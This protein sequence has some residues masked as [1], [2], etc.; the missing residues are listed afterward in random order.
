MTP[1]LT[2][3]K[4]PSTW[5]ENGDLKGFRW[6]RGGGANNIAALMLYAAMLHRIDAETGLSKGTYNQ[7][8]DVL[9]ISREKVSRGIDVLLAHKL[10][11]SDNCAQSEYRISNYDP[12]G[13]WAKF[14]CKRMYRSGLIW[15]F[16]DF[17]LRKR[18]EL[19]ALKLY[20]L[21]V[22]RRDRQTNHAK[23]SYEKISEFTGINRTAISTGNTILAVNGLIH[24]MQLT[25]GQSE[26]GIVNAYRLPHLEPYTHAGT[27][28]RSQAVELF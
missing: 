2:W 18:E 9:N 16:R 27:R 7:F 13:G 22:S 26:H 15:G 6:E 10:I 23:I 20:F 12:D 1:P 3:V 8:T 11:N 21:Y 14:P 17:K 24:T 4:M 28:G 19:D 25:S 5:I